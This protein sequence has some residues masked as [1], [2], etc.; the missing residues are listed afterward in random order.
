M[1]TDKTN[2]K[3][4]AYGDFNVD[5]LVGAMRVSFIAEACNA[6]TQNWIPE[7][8]TSRLDYTNVTVRSPAVKQLLWVPRPDVKLIIPAEK[9]NITNWYLSE[10]RS[11][12]T[13]QNSY[14]KNKDDNSGLQFVSNDTDSKT[15]V[16]PYPVTGQHPTLGANRNLSDFSSLQDFERNTVTLPIK[17][18]NNLTDTYYLTKITMNIWIEGTDS[19][20][21]RAMD[22]GEFNLILTF[23]GT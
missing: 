9:G 3:K 23:S 16:S 22:G 7:N 15:V 2:S 5:A 17:D 10:E 13:Y 12:A 20:A 1:I 11:G 4:S 18:N 19:E 14:Y 21:R 8:E 6:V